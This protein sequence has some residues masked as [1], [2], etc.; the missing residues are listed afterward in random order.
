M[1]VEG[2]VEVLEV[3]VLEEV[4]GAVVLEVVLEALARIFLARTAEY[5]R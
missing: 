2:V 1:A 3:V 5:W 4:F